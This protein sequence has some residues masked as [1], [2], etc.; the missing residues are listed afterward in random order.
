MTD[1][2]QIDDPLREMR[3][4]YSEGRLLAL[5]CI[6][7]AIAGLVSGYGGTAILLRPV[8]FALPSSAGRRTSRFL[9]GAVIAAYGAAAI[10]RILAESGSMGELTAFGGV[11]QLILIIMMSVFVAF[12]EG[13]AERSMTIAVVGASAT[14]VWTGL[15]LLP[16]ISDLSVQLAESWPAWPLLLAY[17]QANI[18]LS[19]AL[20]RYIRDLPK[21]KA[22]VDPGAGEG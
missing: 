7:G 14:L 12:A 16:I 4:G 19:L 10:W 18:V 15:L 1:A 3:E 17:A 11:Q 20:G 21:R 8:L 9:I 13:L 2:P 22:G 5:R 6:A